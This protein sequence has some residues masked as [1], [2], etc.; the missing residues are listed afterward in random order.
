MQAAEGSYAFA[1]EAH[2]VIQK[3]VLI[4]A[5]TSTLLV[6]FLF[7]F[8]YRKRFLVL[9][10]AGI[11]LLTALSWTLGI[12]YLI[13]GSLNMASSVITAMLMGLGIDYIIHIFNRYETEFIETGGIRHSLDAAL[14]KTAPGVVTGALITSA[15]FFSIKATSFKGLYQLGIVAGIGVLACL[16]STIIIMTSLIVFIENYKHGLLF[17]AKEQRFGM[18]GIGRIIKNYPR[19]IIFAG[20]SLL[21][22]SF[23]GL[24]GIRFNNDPEAI[25]PAASQV[26]LMEEEIAEGFGR[27]KNPLM[28][29]AADENKENL[30]EQ[31]SRLESAIERWEDKG[32]ISSHSGLNLFLPPLYKQMDALSALKEIRNSINLD[33]MENKFKKALEENG[34][35]VDERYAAYINGIKNAVEIREPLGLGNVNLSV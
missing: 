27:Q 16:V 4:N 21:L 5:V 32:I 35:A 30:M 2:A 1:M 11:T 34:F 18:D 15:A 25:G 23:I 24:S 8:V 31:Y 20:I 12:A 22:V 13:F 29:T 17:S 6:F 7:Q 19:A 28:I 14:T 10:I 3:D 9:A 33:E 26:M